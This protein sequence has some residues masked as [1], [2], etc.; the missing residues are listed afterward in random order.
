MKIW[1][2]LTVILFLAGLLAIGV[3]SMV[4]I[5][6]RDFPDEFVDEKRPVAQAEEFSF[7]ALWEKTYTPALE[8]AYSDRFPGRVRWMQLN[9]KIGEVQNVLSTLLMSNEQYIDGF[10]I[11]Y[12]VNDE[13]R[14][15]Y[16]YPRNEE[17]MQTF[18]GSI[19]ALGAE[20]KGECWVGLMQIPGSYGVYAPDRLVGDEKNQSRLIADA[21]ALVTEAVHV[22]IVAAM[23][24]QVANG[25]VLDRDKLLYYRADHHWTIYGAYVAYTQLCTAWGLEPV[26]LESG[27]HGYVTGFTGQWVGMLNKLNARL[28]EINA[29]PDVVD[30][31]TMPTEIRYAEAYDSAELTNGWDERVL[32]RAAQNGDA[33]TYGVFGSDHTAMKIVT[34]NETGRVLLV[35]KDSYTNALLSLLVTQFDVIVA[36]DYRKLGDAG[37]P[38]LSMSE[39]ARRIGATHVLVSVSAKAAQDPLCDRFGLIMP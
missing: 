5:A 1:D 29:N 7:K 14:I 3:F 12:D 35:A 31:Y 30:Y 13:L 38:P 15:M 26:P 18:A 9:D 22:D 24:D 37:Q 34:Y 27:R 19:N 16:S 23:R 28:T 11:A 2:K 39:L 10:Y 20:L 25:T 36:I 17:H 6:A 32:Y 21:A 33:G 8:N 4:Y